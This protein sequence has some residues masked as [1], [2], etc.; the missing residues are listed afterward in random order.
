MTG[1]VTIDFYKNNY[2]GNSIPDDVLQGMLDKASTD[3]DNLT[4][5]R[6]KKLGGFNNLSDF[7]KLR[8]QLA[9]CSQADHNQFKSS[10]KGFSSYSIGDVSISLKDDVGDY[11]QSCVNYLKSTRLMYRGL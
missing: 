4:R 2:K 3:I 5:M 9:V 11:S 6:I 10:I 7:E 8:V 1:Y